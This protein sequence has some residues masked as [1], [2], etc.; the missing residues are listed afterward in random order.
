MFVHTCSTC[1]RRQLV[2]PTQLTGATNSE[3]GIVV[4]FTCWCGSPQALLTGRSVTERDAVEP[5]AAAAA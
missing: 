4:T 1:Q 3:H 5:V 2:F